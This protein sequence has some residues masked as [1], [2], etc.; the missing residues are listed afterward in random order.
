M[1][2]VGGILLLSGSILLVWLLKKNKTQP[3]PSN[4]K[5]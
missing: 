5:K 2:L 4:Q 1:P 3:N